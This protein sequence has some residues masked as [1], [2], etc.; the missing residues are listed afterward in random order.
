[1][2]EQNY[3]FINLDGKLIESENDERMRRKHGYNYGSLKEIYPDVHK[4]PETEIMPMIDKLYEADEP[5]ESTVNRVKSY[6]AEKEPEWKT[7][8]FAEKPV[9]E[10]LIDLSKAYVAPDLQTNVQP[11]NYPM[12]ARKPKR[13]TDVNTLLKNNMEAIQNDIDQEVKRQQEAYQENQKRLQEYYDKGFYLTPEQWKE[14]ALATGKGLV[15]GLE[16]A[17]DGATGGLYGIFNDLIYDT[18][19]KKRK[20]EIYQDAVQSD[21]DYI[22]KLSNLVAQY[23]AQGYVG[24]KYYAPFISNIKK[25]KNGLNYVTKKYLERNGWY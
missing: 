16:T 13:N 24:G 3:P 14:V 12:P 20:D 2:T 22:Y 23:G 17:F 11:L 19:Y 25:Y 21:L 5:M 15:S 9:S 4:L 6:I 7:T 18:G 1:M 8:Y 10:N